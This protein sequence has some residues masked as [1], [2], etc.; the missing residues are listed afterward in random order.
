MRHPHG[1]G[2][3]PGLSI[4]ESAGFSSPRAAL[5]PDKCPTPPVEMRLSSPQPPRSGFVPFRRASQA[6][7]GEMKPRRN[8]A[9][10]SPE[11]RARRGGSQRRLWGFRR[12]FERSVVRATR[13][14][15]VRWRSRGRRARGRAWTESLSGLLA[16]HVAVE[17]NTSPHGMP[18][19]N[20][21]LVVVKRGLHGFQQGGARAGRS[22]TVVS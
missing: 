8:A 22:G 9:E 17:D 2:V 15:R 12:E 1:Q 14:S 4:R 19:P 18:P 7:L 20:R 16:P 13:A 10:R 11:R 5:L 21:M 3:R 6:R